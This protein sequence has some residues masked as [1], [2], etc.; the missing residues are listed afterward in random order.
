VRPHGPAA[1]T[2]L[3]AD[4]AGL[5]DLPVTPFSSLEAVDDGDA[6]Y[7]RLLDEVRGA[8]REVALEM[9]QIRPDTVGLAVARALAGAAARGVRVRLLA[10]AWGS[11][12]FAAQ[13]QELREAGVETRWYGPWRPWVSPLR[14]THRKLVVIDGELASVGGM[15]LGEEFSEAASGDRAWRDVSLWLGGGAARELARQFEAAWG[16]PPP[17]A[18]V[19]DATPAAGRCLVVGGA[20]G[21]AGHAAAYRALVD[22]A[23]EEI[24]FANPYF[25]PD[26][27][28]RGR[29]AAAAARGVR[30]TVVIPRR[31]DVPPFKHAARRLYLGL[32]R[33][34]VRIVERADRMVHAKVA[35]VDAEVAAV[36]STNVNRRSF[37]WN[38]ETLVLTDHPATVAR[39]GRFVREEGC[40][41]GEPITLNEWPRHPDRRR[42]AELL[43]ASVH[44][45]F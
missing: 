36:G 42:V 34:G 8:R 41:T 7:R 20:D 11:H 15:N 30:V 32:L 10:D 45:L 24:L 22:R 29:L 19:P 18:P 21:R 39:L 3:L 14:R 13:L 37:Y 43:A 25:M 4:L 38:S 33:R 17:P 26:S 28:F 1:G 16:G 35:V 9:Y 2:L 31:C 12:R 40:G 27:D 23:R 6:H 44:V 5:L